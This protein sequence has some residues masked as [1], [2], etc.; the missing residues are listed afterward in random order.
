[1]FVSVIVCTHSLNNYK[2]LKDAINSLLNQTHKKM[3]IIIVVDGNQRLYEKIVKD[4]DNQKKIKVVASRKNIGLSGARNIGIRASRGDI[5]A[6]LDDDA[7]ADKK[8]LKELLKVYKEH[9][10][11]AVGGK[12]LPKWETQKP[13]FLP[14]EYYWLIGVTYKGFPEK[15]A[16]VR[17]T[18]GS[19]LSFK[20]EALKVLG[21]FRTEMGVR[22]KRLLQAEE[23][24]LCERMREKF[25][26]RVV[27][28]PDAIVYHKVFPERLRMRFLLRRAFWQG[29]SKR[30]MKEMG[31]S[32]SE[33]SDFLRNLMFKSIPER[34]KKAN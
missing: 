12:L 15:V 29:Y 4:Y 19:N 10:A 16:E 30:V 20:A 21:G 31:Y 8:W 9:D 18:F 11:I 22:G 17:N 1:M 27:Y 13:K 25:G 24:E 5:I 26:R 14:E 6:F 23:T 3:E 33:E 32:M 28:N 7:I 34:L 2:N